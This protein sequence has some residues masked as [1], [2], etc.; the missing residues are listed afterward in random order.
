MAERWWDLACVGHA[1]ALA[2]A[3]KGLQRAFWHTCT[4]WSCCL[5]NPPDCDVG[6]LASCLRA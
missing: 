4:A 6:G 3:E 2:V 1:C 5:Q